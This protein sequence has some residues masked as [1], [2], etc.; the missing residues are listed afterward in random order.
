M[1]TW[2][3]SWSMAGAPDQDPGRNPATWGEGPSHRYGP[4]SD[5]YELFSCGEQ[6]MD[7]IAHGYVASRATDDAV[8]RPSPPLQ[9]HPDHSQ[10]WGFSTTSPRSSRSFAL[11]RSSSISCP[12]PIARRTTSHHRSRRIRR[13]HG[14]S[15]ITIHRQL[16][17]T[18]PAAPAQRSGAPGC[19]PTGTAATE[20]LPSAPCGTLSHLHH[21]PAH[22]GDRD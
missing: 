4:T 18:V 21:R 15:H 6:T 12:R 22:E 3:G 17:H 11:H 9:P 5:M 14:V 1:S 13:L 2:L 20:G 19:P 7:Q 16:S 10:P 8:Y